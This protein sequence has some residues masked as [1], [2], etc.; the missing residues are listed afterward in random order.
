MRDGLSDIERERLSSVCK[1]NILCG[2]RGWECT[3]SAGRDGLHYPHQSSELSAIINAFALLPLLSLCT[4]GVFVGDVGQ[5]ALVVFSASLMGVGW[6]FEEVLPNLT[7]RSNLIWSLIMSS[8]SVTASHLCKCCSM[9]QTNCLSFRAL[10]EV[11]FYRPLVI[12]Y[13]TNYVF[14]FWRNYS[15]TTHLLNN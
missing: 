10:I 2:P 15:T 8:L 4:E 13:L 5:Q 12:L 3:A 11:L 7:W 14:E 9:V 6:F 1:P